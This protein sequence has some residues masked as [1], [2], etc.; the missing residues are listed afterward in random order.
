MK[1]TAIVR[2]AGIS[3]AAL[4][5]TIPATASALPKGP[6]SPLTNPA[7]ITEL[8]A[9]AY[10]W[11]VAPEFVYRFL[12]YNALRTAPVNM[13]GGKG[14]QAAA[15]N[16]LATNAGDASVLYLNSML[17]LSGRK[18]PSSQNG[19]TKELVLTVPPSAQNYYVVNVLDSFINSTGSMGTR[20]T[21]SNKRQTYLVVGPT[22]QYANKRTARI[23]GK[24]FRVMTQ[25]TNLGWILI[26]IRADSLVPS[27]NPASV[28]AVDETVVKRFALNTLA[29]YQKN[30]YRPIYPTTTSYPPSNQQIQRSEKWAN[31]PAQATAFMAQLGQSL[32]Q[33]PMPSRNTGI[34][35]TPLKA[36]PAW[37]V[38]QANAKK[39]Y[40]NPS[41]GQERQLRLLKPLGLTA[42]G[43]KLPRNWGTDQLNALQA[44]Y[45]KGDAG[46]TDL[47]TA[48]GVSAAT[49]YWSFLN[50]NIGTYPNNLLGWAFRAV[51]VQ[52]GGSANV[53]PDAVYAQ[54]NQTA[55]TAATQMVGDNTYSMT[56]TPPP[57][58]GAPLPANGTMPPMVNDSSGNPKGFWSVHLYQTDPTES[59]APYLTQASVLNLAY[60]QANQTVVSVDA[61][62]DTITVNMP[63]WG[64]APVASTPIFFGTGASAYGFKPNTPYY[65]ATTPTTAGSG[66]T[67]TYTFK[68]SATWQQQLSPGNVPIQGPDGTPTNMVDVQAGSGTLQWGPIQPVSQLGSQQLTSGQLKKNADGSVTLW[69]GPT[70]P[71]GAPAT[72]WLPSPSQAYYQQVYGKA[73][74]PTNIRPLLRMYYPTPGSDTAPSILQPPSGATQSTWVPPLVTKVG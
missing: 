30:R 5:V 72:N 46:V 12:K 23:G 6:P 17:D 3:A 11:G 37:V 50:T 69:I 14:T 34:G 32:A 45:E 19:G 71:A 65:V 10:T 25:D 59:K 73:G 52:E 58:P 62:A 40:Q 2:A 60:S 18:Y 42:K 64:G 63:T 55:G 1:R 21:P 33:S 66:S 13:L 68:V 41:F 15:W 54:I 48:V 61:S 39:L 56:F 67:A 70:L 53:P 8:A 27:S 16:N 22:S 26:R 49:N 29:Q 57:A 28:N 74:M 51:I 20:T 4:I 24:V 43:W 47:S 35:N 44:G 38:P 36:L 31:A 9:D 7:A